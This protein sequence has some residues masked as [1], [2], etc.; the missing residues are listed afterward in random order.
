MAKIFPLI[1][2][3]ELE[4]NIFPRLTCLFSTKAATTGAKLGEISAIS[5]FLVCFAFFFT[6]PNSL[7]TDLRPVTNQNKLAKHSPR[8]FHG[9]F[10]APLFGYGYV[11]ASR[12]WS[13]RRR[14]ASAAPDPQPGTSVFFYTYTRERP[15]MSGNDP[16]Q[17]PHLRWPLP[18]SPAVRGWP[19]K[20]QL[21]S[22]SCK[23]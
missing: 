9:G 8:I 23:P 14:K 1:F 15:G 11:L 6:V 17:A 2:R 18:A 4:L 21:K 3:T 7:A 10:R 22:R 20:S 16:R 5:G 19:V 12:V 13:K